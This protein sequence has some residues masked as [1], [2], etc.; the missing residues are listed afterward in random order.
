[1]AQKRPR[2]FGQ[3]FEDT[4]FPAYQQSQ[5]SSRQFEQQKTLAQLKHL[6]EQPEIASKL[7]VESQNIA[8]SKQTGQQEA[9]MQPYIIEEAKAL[10]SQRFAKA[11][12]L[13]KWQ[14]F[15]GADKA[16]KLEQTDRKMAV[17]IA[18]KNP[19][20]Q[21]LP[22]DEKQLKIIEA[23]DTLQHLKSYAKGTQ[24]IPGEKPKPTSKEV[25][26]IWMIH[27]TTGKR[28]EVP[29]SQKDDAIKAGFKLAE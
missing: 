24:P 16:D 22:A 13:R 29:V 10:A 20:F 27:P 2:G 15:S 3:G 11:E 21:F 18:G 4:F 26:K 8:R 12:Q 19:M 23:Y 6:L 5:Q 14:N 28:G 17:D 7:A 9:E 25:K 1:M